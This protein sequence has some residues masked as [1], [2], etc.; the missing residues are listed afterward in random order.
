MTQAD[1][2][3]QSVDPNAQTSRS[4]QRDK[5]L[6]RGISQAKMDSSNIDLP[7]DEER[8]VRE[9]L[10]DA[11]YCLTDARSNP[12]KREEHLQRGF[13]HLGKARGILGKSTVQSQSFRRHQWPFLPPGTE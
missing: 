11:S 1:R 5:E 10:A 7:Y 2:E 6:E 4:E 8:T 12:D 13:Y 3:R 9:Y